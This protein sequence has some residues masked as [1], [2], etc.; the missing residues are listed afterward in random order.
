MARE[1]ITVLAGL[2]V[3]AM[4]SA[5]KS[6]TEDSMKEAIVALYMDTNTRLPAIS[7]AK[8]LVGKPIASSTE[9]APLVIQAVR[10]DEVR[11]RIYVI[12]HEKEQ[13]H[14]I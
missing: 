11:R 5:Q 7:L 3:D 2:L 13:E 9:L 12:A 14:G 10:D 6:I 1:Q 4:R 8:T